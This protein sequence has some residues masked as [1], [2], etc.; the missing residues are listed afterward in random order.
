MGEITDETRKLLSEAAKKNGL[1]GVVLVDRVCTECSIKFK[2]ISNQLRCSKC[3][4]NGY[5]QVCLHCSS[6]FYSKCKTTKYCTECCS[7]KAWLVGKPRDKSIG[8]KITEAKL[9]FYQTDEGK[10]VAKR[11][12]EKNSINMINYYKTDDG[13]EAKLRNA[14]IHSKLMKE[15]IYN[16]EFTPNITNSFTHWDAIIKLNGITYKFRSSWEACFWLCNNHLAYEKYRIPYISVDGINRIYIAD[17]FDYSNNI[18]YEIKPRSRYVKEQYKMDMVIK[19]CIS[20]NIKFIWINEANIMKYIDP[21]NFNDEN[22][23]QL[24]KMYEGIGY[25]E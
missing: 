25:Y 7:T 22:I 13:I 2:G 4:A 21:S 15:K 1:G 11:I 10:S 19:H 3:K 9:K 12:G 14:E 17:F 20:N 24:K 23:K 18:L 8:K 16:S 5:N 6:E